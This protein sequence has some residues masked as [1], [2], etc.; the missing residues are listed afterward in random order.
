MNI[1]TTFTVHGDNAD[2]LMDQAIN[3][4]HS[5]ADPHLFEITLF[6]VN[7]AVESNAQGILYWQAEVSIEVSM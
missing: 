5:F 3:V 4:A 7:P 2:D 1:T 6:I